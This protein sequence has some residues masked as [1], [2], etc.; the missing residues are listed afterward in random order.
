MKNKVVSR[1]RRINRISQTGLR[2]IA[3]LVIATT[4]FVESNAQQLVWR[5]ASGLDAG[6]VAR[7]FVDG[8]DRVYVA[9]GGDLFTSTDRGDT[10]RDCWPQGA[11]VF[12]LA[13]N[14]DGDIFASGRD[15][16]FWRSTD[17]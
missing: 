4:V 16:K 12:E 17:D 5:R 9:S 8:D 13:V 11:S 1:C 14:R 15:G 3:L 10:W 2:C 6:V 7:I